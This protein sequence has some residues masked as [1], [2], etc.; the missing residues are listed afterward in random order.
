M[1]CNR[2]FPKLIRPAQLRYDS[3]LISH[4]PHIIDTRHAS[5]VDKIETELQA[6]IRQKLNKKIRKTFDRFLNF[7]EPILSDF[8]TQKSCEK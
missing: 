5:L 7:N 2:L 8:L 6:L 1:R 3:K 4:R